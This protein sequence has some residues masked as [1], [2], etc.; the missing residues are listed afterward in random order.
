MTHPGRFF[1]GTV[2]LGLVAT[3]APGTGGLSAESPAPQSGDDAQHRYQ[4]TVTNINASVISIIIIIIIIIIY[5][6]VL[7][8]RESV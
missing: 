5:G 7:E 8:S 1:A 6:R 2:V 3:F 4:V